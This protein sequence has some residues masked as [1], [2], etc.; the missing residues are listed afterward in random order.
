M[1][2]TRCV[3]GAAVG[4][5]GAVGGGVGVIVV[6]VVVLVQSRYVTLLKQHTH[7]IRAKSSN[8][9]LVC[10]SQY[11]NYQTV[12]FSKIADPSICQNIEKIVA[13]LNLRS[14]LHNSLN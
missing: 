2:G 7:Q 8:G 3:G 12:L 14:K 6:V 4:A 11:P 5:I 10:T 13:I 9:K 1:T